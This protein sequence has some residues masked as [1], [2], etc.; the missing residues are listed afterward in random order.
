MYDESKSGGIS[1]SGVY[2]QKGADACLK[3]LR[4]RYVATVT[5]AV[6]GDRKS[7]QREAKKLCSSKKDQLMSSTGYF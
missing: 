4:Q 3:A 5:D 1:D 6:S 2:G 7:S